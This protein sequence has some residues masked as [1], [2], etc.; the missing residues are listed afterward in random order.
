MEKTHLRQ[1]TLDDLAAIHQINDSLN[2]YI[3]N[4]YW[5]RKYWIKSQIE[6]GNYWVATIADKVV[7]AMCI[8]EE[9]NELLIVAIA[10]DK[11]FRSRQIGKTLVNQ[12]K[13]IAR[14]RKKKELTVGSFVAYKVK[15]FYCRCGF[16][17]L[18]EMGDYNGWLYYN[19]VIKLD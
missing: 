8:K 7:G 18:S 15:D 3:P 10:V 5:I 9:E 6:T 4:S 1:A 11:E 14:K 16:K 17:L 13:K 19:F 12:A 2:L